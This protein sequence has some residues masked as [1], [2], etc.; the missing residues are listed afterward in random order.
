MSDY[1]A[2]EVLELQHQPPVSPEVSRVATI[3]EVTGDG[4]VLESI[5]ELSDE[6]VDR[7]LAGMNKGS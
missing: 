3:S 7:L 1:I 6:D 2:D 4:G 5:E